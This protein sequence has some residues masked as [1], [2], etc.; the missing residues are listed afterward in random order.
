MRE[1]Q[2]DVF[3]EVEGYFKDYAEPVKLVLL[4]RTFARRVKALGTTIKNVVMSDERLV[5]RRARNGGFKVL[6]K[7]LFESAVAP[8]NREKYYTTHKIDT[9]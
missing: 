7:E 3:V 4:N 8:V 9:L 6:P 2:D 5:V 1:L